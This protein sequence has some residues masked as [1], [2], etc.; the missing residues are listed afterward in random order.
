MSRFFGQAISNQLL[1]VVQGSKICNADVY[2]EAYS[3][4]KSGIYLGGFGIRI[5]RKYKVYAALSITVVQL[6]LRPQSKGNTRSTV[7]MYQYTLDLG[8]RNLMFWAANT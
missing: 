6:L 2:G 4:N 1:L 7:R 3:E 5:G 8:N